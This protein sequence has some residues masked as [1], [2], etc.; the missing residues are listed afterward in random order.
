M[1]VLNRALGELSTLTGCGA[2][3]KSQTNRPSS[4]IV[5]YQEDCGEI[6]D[7]LRTRMRCLKPGGRWSCRPSHPG[8]CDVDKRSWRRLL[9]L[10]Q[11]FLLWSCRESNQAQKST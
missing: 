3:P 8:E 1:A 5:L 2:A 6:A 11:R 4:A 9:R 10:D 7:P